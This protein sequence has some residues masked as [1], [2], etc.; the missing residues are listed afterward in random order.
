MTTIFLSGSR[1][2]SHLDKDV[3]RRLQNI[4]DQKFSVVV[5]DANGIDK[6]V[7]K[8][9]F[10]A[11]YKDVTV[12]CSGS[13]CRNNI[14]GWQ[15]K[16]ILVSPKL[17]GR[18]FYTEKD[19]SMASDADYGFVLWDGKS[20]GSITNVMELIKNNKKALVYYSP[21][22]T[23]YKITDVD[24]A[25]KLI[26]NCSQDLINKLQAKLAVNLKEKSEVQVSF[27]F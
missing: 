2:I 8:F 18:D 27:G 9:F 21:Q 10:E 7:Q 15:T 26:S 14:G 16:S 25:S 23:F 6:A 1:N 13:N 11:G 17:K 12:Y 4:I 19:K 22:R 24:D 3:Q 20:Q 5:G